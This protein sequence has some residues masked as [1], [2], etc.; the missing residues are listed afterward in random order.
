MV[1][2]L[3]EIAAS[4]GPKLIEGNCVAAATL[5]KLREDGFFRRC[6]QPE[7]RTVWSVRVA[8]KNETIYLTITPEIRGFTSEEDPI[9]SAFRQ[10]GI[11]LHE[12]LF[13]LTGKTFSFT[14]NN[15]L[16]LY[17]RLLRYAGNTYNP[18]EPPFRGHMEKRYRAAQ[19]I[20]DLV[21]EEGFMEYAATRFL[22]NRV[23]KRFSSNYVDLDSVVTAQGRLV[24]IEHKRKYP[25]KDGYLT[26]D[27]ELLDHILDFRKRLGAYTGYLVTNICGYGYQETKQR[28]S[29]IDYLDNTVK[30]YW[31]P[32]TEDFKGGK[33][34]S[35]KRGK[36]G[37][38]TKDNIR[39]Q[40][41]LPINRFIQFSS[42]N[43]SLTDL[44][45]QCPDPR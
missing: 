16:S 2:A 17:N 44:M 3:F 32:I 12:F 42:D 15:G 37:S 30:R 22:A 26:L 9:F 19:Y 7:G 8:G 40:K 24:S 25:T 14:G 6:D 36:S 45:D 31:T 13:R 11:T 10:K 43:T 29:V 28:E 4:D 41:G 35:T 20:R 34:F 18:E 33:D 27:L 39:G 38:F 23:L 1:D 5:Q 21:G